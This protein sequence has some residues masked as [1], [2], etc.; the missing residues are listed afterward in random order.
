MS[1]LGADMWV[2]Q[3]FSQAGFFLDVGC[4]DGLSELSNSLLLEQNGWRGLCIDAFPRNFSTRTSSIV[5]QA[6][7]YSEKD[8]NVEFIVPHF[9]ND[10][11]GNNLAGITSNDFGGIATELG[12]HR[13]VVTR[14]AQD[15]VT[16]KTSLLHELLET[17]KAPPFMEYMNLDIEGSEYEVLRTFPFERYRFGCI[18]LEHNF[19]EPKRTAMEELLLKHK[20][21]KVREVEF[22]DWYVFMPPR[23]LPMVCV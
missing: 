7:L 15:I 19:E 21:I 10:F 13:E 16:L 8:K 17:Y 14:N 20:Y 5:V 2:L 18:S 4:G 22:D 11:L 12:L 6:V 23:K 3:Q 1:Q 9:S